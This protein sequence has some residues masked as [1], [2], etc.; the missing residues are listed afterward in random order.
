MKLKHQRL[1]VTNE[2]ASNDVFRWVK[3]IGFFVVFVSFPM[4]IQCG[5]WVFVFVFNSIGQQITI[6][7][8]LLIG[9]NC[10]FRDQ[11]K[12]LIR[13]LFTKLMI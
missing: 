5:R 6:R 9:L 4:I 1:I 11:L 7:F 8:P 12:L 10:V 3:F 2:S 13:V